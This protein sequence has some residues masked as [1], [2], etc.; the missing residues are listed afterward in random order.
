MFPKNYII[1]LD[2]SYSMRK[3]MYKVAKGINSFIYKINKDNTQSYF[4]F[5]IFHDE[6]INIS[7]LQDTS[8]FGLFNESS[9]RQYGCTALYDSL[10]KF[11]N[12]YGEIFDNF[13][14]YMYIISDGEDNKSFRYNVGEIDN[15]LELYSSKGWNI[16][17]CDIDQSEFS[18]KFID[19]MVYDVDNIDM[20]FDN[21]KIN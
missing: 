7:F 11:F 2:A 18:M 16:V 14:N 9:I 20:L 8:V 19:T 13:T 17:H 15:L 6:L 12:E 5:F 21:L 1:F 3:N 4:T 10:G